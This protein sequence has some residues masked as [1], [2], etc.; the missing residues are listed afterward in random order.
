MCWPSGPTRSSA[1][2]AP[3]SRRR[4]NSWLAVW[5]RPEYSRASSSRCWPTIGPS[6]WVAVLAII[7]AGAAVSPLDTQITMGALERVLHDSE[8]RF[9]LRR[10]ST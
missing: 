7:G 2:A 10:R 8:A 3:R 1:G 5:W 6:G 4:R 9:I